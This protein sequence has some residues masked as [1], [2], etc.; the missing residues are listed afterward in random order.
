MSTA[1][2]LADCVVALE[3]RRRA[4]CEEMDGYGSPVAA[5]DADYNALVLERGELTAAIARLA[6]IAR[7]EA[8]ITHPLHD[9]HR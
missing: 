9:S 2:S 6:P 8:H 7:G 3:A 1:P 5:C 4:V